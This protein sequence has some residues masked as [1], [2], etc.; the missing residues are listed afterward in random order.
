MTQDPPEDTF[1][2]EAAPDAEP[3]EVLDAEERESLQRVERG[4]IP[5]EAERRLRELGENGG[6][7]T[8]D[9]SVAD[10]ALCHGLGLRPLAQV[11]GSSI[12]QVASATTAQWPSWA[13]GFM[14]ELNYLSDAWNEVRDR[15]LH[16]LALEAQAVGADAVVGVDLRTGAHDFVENAI[17]YVVLGTAVR[18]GAAASAQVGPPASV[19]APTAGSGHAAGRRAQD[20]AHRGPGGEP[21][22]TELSVAD[23]ANLRRAGVEP[24]GVV[25]WSAAYYV[26]ASFNTQMMGG[27]GAMTYTNQELPEFTE[28]VYS[29]REAVMGR[30]TAQAAQLGATGVIGARINHS[31]QRYELNSAGRGSASG[32]MVTF[33]AIGTAIRET[34]AATLYA[35]EMTM[36][37]TT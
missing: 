19:Q 33:H 18:Q 25:A 23:Y 4:G 36:D 29:A 37:L 13:G 7:F 20:S 26:R 27:L 8:S 24:L 10:F 16:R 9:L 3:G 17:E 28:G 15:A 31:A 1:D 32:L 30:M 5:I 6:T 2:P 21:V 11:M 12:Y 34:E 14:F 35:P 22:L